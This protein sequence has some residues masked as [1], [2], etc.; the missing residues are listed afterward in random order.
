MSDK[1][2]PSAID[3]DGE[4]YLRDSQRA[5]R[6]IAAVK[7]MDLLMDEMVRTTLAEAREVSAALAAF[8]QR[9]FERVGGLQALLA[10][11]YDAKIGGKKPCHAGSSCARAAA[12]PCL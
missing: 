7:P 3:I 6:P 11:D 8:K 12:K 4:W 9:T 1:P 5:L 2:H 10:Q